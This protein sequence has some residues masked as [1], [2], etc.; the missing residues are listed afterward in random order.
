M[1]SI[2]GKAASGD[3]HGL[4]ELVANEPRHTYLCG[5]PR[6]GALWMGHGFTPQ[7]MLELAPAE[8]AEEFPDW[9]H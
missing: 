6:C 5:C 2:C 1:C 4:D 9:R 7:L 3:W 8:A